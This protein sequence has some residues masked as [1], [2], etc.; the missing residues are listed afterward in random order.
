MRVPTLP[1]DE[2][3]RLEALRRYDV[4][5]TMPEQALDD[6]VALAAHICATP[7]SMMSLVDETRQWFKAKVGLHVSETPRDVAFCGH[8]LDLPDL[9]IVPDALDDERFADN[10]LVVGEPRS[11]AR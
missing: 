11:G 3:A 9:V 2:P 7:I 1:S 8:A 6:L 4:L 5:D 10:P